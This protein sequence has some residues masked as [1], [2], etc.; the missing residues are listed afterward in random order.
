[1]SN[2]WI[3][4]DGD[5]RLYLFGQKP[6]LHPVNQNWGVVCR[7]CGHMEN[8]FCELGSVCIH[9]LP[10]DMYPELQPCECK[11]LKTM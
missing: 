5:G 11:E 2:L 9:S 1:M 4:R 8:G 10:K 7:H 3:G 6:Y